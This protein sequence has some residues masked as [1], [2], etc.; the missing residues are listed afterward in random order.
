MTEGFIDVET[1][2]SFCSKKIEAK[3]IRRVR[4]VPKVL[5]WDFRKSLVSCR[6]GPANKKRRSIRLNSV[7]LLLL[8]SSGDLRHWP[9]NPGRRRKTVERCW[10]PSRSGL[11]G[12]PCLVR[13]FRELANWKGG[14]Y[15]G[16]G[17][18]RPQKS[19]VL[20]E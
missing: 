12:R 18:E 2:L 8:R 1:A 17:P 10:L 9:N 20:C 15:G 6:T 11:A 5:G 19:A 3:G 7:Q 14:Y 4:A 16:G 13:P